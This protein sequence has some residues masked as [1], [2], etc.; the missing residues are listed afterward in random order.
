MCICVCMYVCAFVHLLIYNYSCFATGHGYMVYSDSGWVYCVCTNIHMSA[1]V[2]RD[3]E[4]Y[5]SRR[6][7]VGVGDN[8]LSIV[9]RAHVF[10][11]IWCVGMRLRVRIGM[12]CYMY[13]QACKIKFYYQY[14][15]SLYFI[16][17]KNTLSTLMYMSVTA[18]QSTVKS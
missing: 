15:R 2:T 11:H 4:V 3:T 12:I 8:R 6:A 17:S 14:A 18:R 16:D 10:V 9:Y 1:Y 7:C 5:L 13:A